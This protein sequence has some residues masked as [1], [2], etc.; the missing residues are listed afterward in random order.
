MR[1]TGGICAMREE[2]SFLL[3]QTGNLY[4]NLNSLQ[5]HVYRGVFEFAV[6]ILAAGEDIRCWQAHVGQL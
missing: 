3:S 4:D 6:E 1:F 2:L 5:H